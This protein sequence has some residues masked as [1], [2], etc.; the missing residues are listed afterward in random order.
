MVEYQQ[1]HMVRSISDVNGR[2]AV[3]STHRDYNVHAISEAVQYCGSA[4]YMAHCTH[5]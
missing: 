4:R 3:T 1:F 5:L 2:Y